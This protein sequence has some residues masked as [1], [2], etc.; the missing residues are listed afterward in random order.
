MRRIL[1]TI[2]VSG[3]CACSDRNA[4]PNPRDPEPGDFQKA[5]QAFLA[6]IEADRLG[7]AY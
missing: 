7:A 3:L 2:V 6:E 5:R 1:L 4:R